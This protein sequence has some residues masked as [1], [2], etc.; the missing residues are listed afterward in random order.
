M[1]G[2]YGTDQLFNFMMAVAMI[3]LIV[4]LFFGSTIAGTVLW[5]TALVVLVLGYFRCFSRKTGNRFRENQRYLK[6]RNRVTGAFRSLFERI[7]QSKTHRFFKCPSCSQTVRVPKGKGK[8]R[9]R[10]PKCGESFIRKS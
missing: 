7:K 1:I 8:I 3:L 10:C 5:M 2:R 6:I 4:S 9:I